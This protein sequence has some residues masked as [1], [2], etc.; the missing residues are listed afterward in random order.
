MEKGELIRLR[1]P[2]RYFLLLILLGAATL[3]LYD[4]GYRPMHGDEANQAMKTGVLLETGVYTY[5]PFEHHGPTLY[6]LT[7]PV[8]W[9]NGVATKVDMTE[10]MIRVVPALFGIAL[11]GLSFLLVA[12]IDR[13]AGLLAALLVAISHGLTYYSRYYIQEMSFVFFAAGLLWCAY[14]YLL[15]RRMAWA[16]GVGAFLG[17]LHATK[18]TSLL[19]VVAMLGALGGVL[20]LERIQ[21]RELFEEL[22]DTGEE[23][24]KPV[25]C[26]NW[27]QL[28]AALAAALVISVVFFS[29]FF[30]H[31]RGPLDSVLTYSTYL[32]RSEGH[33]SSGL[34]DHPWYYYLWI[35]GWYYREAGPKWSEGLILGLALV[36]GIWGMC[37]AWRGD[38]TNQTD[39]TDPDDSS[40]KTCASACTPRIL[41]HFLIVYTLL[42]VGGFSLI[43]YKTPWNLLIFLHPLCL[44]AGLGAFRLLTMPKALWV[45]AAVALL[46]VA[47]A[48]QLTGQT[49]R[50]IFT[51][52]ADVRNP[53][54]YAHTSSAIRRL[55]ERVADLAAV[56]PNGNQLVIKIFR[57]GDDYWPLPWYFRAYPNVGYYRGLAEDCDADIILTS[58][59]VAGAVQERLK[60]E[61]HFENHGLRP[62]VLLPTFIRKNLWDAYMANRGGTAPAKE[63]Q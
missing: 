29:S 45:R 61:Y 38:R 54:V 1:S 48:M 7:L 35:L 26:L 19:V 43:P 13:R 46:L 41:E 32:H 4:L 57:P 20:L 56:H 23:G 12:P 9:L 27:R 52:G 17:L 24:G 15:T 44:L 8:L 16:L 42:L 3:R 40:D 33:G 11:V 51:Y 18:E 39:R 6:Y 14:Y 37:G 49:W 63:T 22:A 50:G 34:H 60:S 28:A 36:G 31:G 59:E 2:E 53:Y 10:A 30:T 47:G 21:F 62:G 58:P 5:D 25:R 55:T